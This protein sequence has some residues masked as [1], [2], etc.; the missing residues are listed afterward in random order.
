[1]PK[2]ILFNGPPKSG[3]D[4]A[5]RVVM[6]ALEDEEVIHLRLSQP[7]KDIAASYFGID[8]KILEANKDAIF[9]TKDL[10]YR[11]AQIALFGAISQV[12]GPAWLG[13]IIKNKIAAIPDAT[14]VISDVGRAS[15]ITSLVRFVGANNI[16]VIQL[17]RRGYTFT[18]DTRGY[19]TIPNVKHE[20]IVNDGND[21]FDIE[22]TDT[23][24]RFIAGTTE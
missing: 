6:K 5:T 2:I 11:N 10:S 8:P 15:D 19:V 21:L 17:Y 3:K 4:H 13:E 9:P 1:M 14:I 23:V 20:M 18:N 7:L 24:L 22:V 16:L 12:F